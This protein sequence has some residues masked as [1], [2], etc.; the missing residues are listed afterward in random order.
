VIVVSNV[1][2]SFGGR[3]LFEDV[4]TSFGPGKRFGLTGPNGAGKSTFMKILIGDLEPDSGTIS[5]PKR[6]GILRQDH[7]LFDHMRVLDV[8]IC[9]NKRL[10]D[11]MQQKDAILAK[12]E[13]TEDDGVLLGELECLIAEE[14]G[15]TAESDAAVLLEGLGI[16]QAAHERPL[17]ELKGGFKLRVLLAQ[18]LFGSPHALL[19]DEPTN[20]LDLESIEWLEE[21]LLEYNGVL[22][23]ISHDRH[24]LNSV[25]T[26]IADIDYETIIQ[27]PGNY[28]DMVRQKAQVRSQVE[29][30]N[31][32][33]MEKIKQLQDFISRFGAGT[34][35]SQAASRKKEI[36]RL[37]PDEIK[38][39]NIARPYIK[40][41]LDKP[42]GREAL[43]V[44]KLACGYGET[45][46]FG[47]LHLSVERGDKVAVIGRNGVGK[48][49]LIETLMGKL[50]PLAGN[51]KWGHEVDVGYFPQEHE[52]LI[53]PGHKVFDWMFEQKP[54]AGK[55]GVRSVLGRLLFSGEDGDKPTAT[56]SGGERV[57]AI[58]ARLMLLRHNTLVLDEPTNH[59]DLEAISALRDGIQSFAG[60][61]IVV[62]HDRD[63]IE[64]VAN[65]IVA[66]EDGKI[67]VYPGGWEEYRKAKK[68]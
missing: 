65:K 9:G 23:V 63:L 48:T 44:H 35:S 39:S 34:R 36:S 66:I 10:W 46:L 50:P 68:S 15:Y 4:T 21:F 11:A 20:H 52:G 38:R 17:S 14:D 54:A 30:S 22:V 62:T 25:C 40:F 8:A 26:H 43:V 61:C 1:S 47:G 18:A 60:T 37:R 12:A 6:L 57:R 28:D 64:S 33:K 59:M 53:P 67:E 42:G 49:T 32:K 41:E 55:E 51:I 27:Y 19:L 31:A 16:P 45:R 13:M 3:K 56:L 5:R 24:F 29:A 7:T 2:K 58:L